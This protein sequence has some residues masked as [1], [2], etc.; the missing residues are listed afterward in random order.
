MLQRDVHPRCSGLPQLRFDTPQHGQLTLIQNS[1]K[2]A[3]RF[4]M[5]CLSLEKLEEI[6]PTSNLQM[7]DRGDGAVVLNVTHPTAQPLND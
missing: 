7:S 4:K 2:A 6:S 5:R 1:V 3:S